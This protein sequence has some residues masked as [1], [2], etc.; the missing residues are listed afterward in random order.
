[1]I[2]SKIERLVDDLIY[3]FS[4]EKLKEIL[5]FKNNNFT[6][7]G[8]NRKRYYEDDFFNEVYFVGEVRLSD[9]SEFVVFAVKIA[10]ELSERS[11]KK[12]QF[13]L[14]KRILKDNLFDAGFFVFYD[15]SK[16]FRF[17]FVNSIYIGTKRDFSHYKRYTYFVERGKPCR[18]FKRALVEL[19][20]DSIESIKSAF[21]VWTLI[22][23]FYTEIQNW[24]AWA[25]KDARV[26]FPGGKKEENLIRL[27]TRLVFVWFL[28]EMKLIPEEVFNEENLLNIVKD[29]KNRDYY[30]NAILQNLF[31]ATLNRPINERGFVRDGDFLENRIHFGLK[32]FYR[33]KNFLLCSE[34]EFIRIFEKTPFINGGLFEC[35]DDDNEY[36]DGFS[37]NE[38]KRAKI[39]DEFFFGDERRE[40]LSDFY[41]DDSVEKVRGIIKILSDYNFTAD[42]NSP[43]DVE[44]SLDPELLG[45]IF[46]N[47]LASYNEE[48]QTTARKATGSY[49]T[50][51]EIVDFMVEES[52]VEYFKNLG[53]D[54]EKIRKLLL[55][56]EEIELSDEE[57]EKLI[58]AID[59]IKVLDPAVGS[60]AFPMGV[61]HKLVYLL[62]RVDPDNNLWY[63]LQ[64]Q[65]ALEET[66]EILKVVDKDQREELL[67]ELNDNF[68]QAITYPDYARKLYLIQNSIYG[69]DVQNI[70]IQ[71]T[72]LRFF[73][74]LI[75]DQKKDFSKENLGVKPL[76]HLET[77][78]IT[79]NT[80][81]FF[82]RQGVLTSDTVKVLK[83]E[84]KKLYKKHFS[85]RTREEKKRI[86]EKAREIRDKIKE[87][88][89]KIGF[90]DGSAQKI[91]D[92]DIF[93]QLA[94]ADWF[95][96][97]WMFGVEGFDIVIG[98]PPYVRQEKIKDLKPILQTQGYSTF[99][100]TADLYVYFYEKGYN[101]LK[102]GGILSYITSNKWMRAKYGQKLRKFLKNNTTLL[103]LIEFK[104]Y[105]VF[106]QTVDTEITIFKKAKPNNNTFYYVDGVP[107]SIEEHQKAIE[108]IK[109]NLKPMAQSKLSDSTFVLGDDKV[110]LLKEKI[111]KVGKPLREWD[112]RIYRGV[113]TGFNEAFIIDSAKREEILRNCKDEEERKR[114]EEIIKPI[115]RGRDIGRYYYRWAGLWVIATFPSKRLNIENYP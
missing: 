70:A 5:E 94:R 102:D 85:V 20:L 64:Y 59:S 25:L 3:D 112:V 38:S 77:N 13:E 9:Q 47:L 53:I 97:E 79:A 55:Y 90:Q 48:T 76:P 52:L 14:A 26:W 66:K 4:I 101:L 24:Y 99:E 43:L 45:H 42:E 81:I 44:V 88:L 103:K 78:F 17:S 8:N 100:G 95:D 80:L 69:V 56:D 21:A 58:H 15:D 19:K 98:N 108:Y 35:L 83:E 86:Q 60:G 41:G 16:N 57:K 115:L 34:E 29:F 2:A 27:I 74:S 104:G 84:L 113:L 51:K 50:P 23:E 96:P 109:A 87:E 107:T 7:Y 6:F 114:T 75:I 82:E 11:S 65:K 10:K 30:Y 105:Q 71:I 31:F 106:R 36:V 73:L 110:L 63:K 33:Y 18:T 22:R 111:E 68:D 28:K 32:S 89:K 67:K 92:F 54:E 40:D 93:N 1:M 91:V 39:P 62:E 72:K 12:K 49:Y 37:R 61:L 46:E